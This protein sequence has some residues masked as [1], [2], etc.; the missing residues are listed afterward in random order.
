MEI[1]LVRQ[2]YTPYG[3]AE[4]FVADAL[5]A[6]RAEGVALKLYTRSWPGGNG[7]QNFEPVICNPFFLGSVWRDRSF[8]RAVRA[9]WAR[10]RPDLVQSHE[11][12][13]GCDVFR[14]GDGVHRIWLQERARGMGV[15]GRIG[16]ALNP[17]H[18][19]TL[20][21]EKR[22][23]SHPALR[24]VICNSA[25]VR[26]QVRA[27]G[28][29]AAKLHLIYNAVDAQR[30]SP[31]LRAHRAEVRAQHSL[32]DSAIVFALVGS[33]YHR[34]GV[35]QAIRAFAR[36]P[37]SAR[38]VVAGRDKHPGRFAARA[39]KLGVAGRVVFAGPL[40]DVGPLLGA[41]DAFVRPTLY[42]PLPN[43]CLEAMAAG[44]P[45][46]TSTQCGAAELLVPHAAGI[47]CDAQDVDALADAM[48]QLLDPATR[49]AMGER[50]RK[51]IAPLT[52]AAMAAQL[53]ALY[54]S[55]LGDHGNP[56]L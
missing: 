54:R 38:L 34:K 6:L 30:F 31:A 48:R 29:D 9:E 50:A 17:Y 44:L 22:L 28:V 19:Y 45:V 43:A 12:I 15:L 55:L 42:D 37:S 23:F 52:A 32:P 4:R 27:F 8:A 46:V 47:A 18:R 26:E 49:W 35:D 16:L 5:A 40:E 13:P 11:R 39:N 53:L 1:G 2:R 7:G 41:A 14:A 33:G 24:A 21:A 56:K 10:H 36:L 51:A 25:L 3:G 20:R